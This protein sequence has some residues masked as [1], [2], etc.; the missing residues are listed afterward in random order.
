MFIS[1]E[2]P[3]YN[4]ISIVYPFLPTVIRR[5]VLIE[6]AGELPETFGLDLDD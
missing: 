2:H 6:W 4:V 1:T 3:L 5:Q